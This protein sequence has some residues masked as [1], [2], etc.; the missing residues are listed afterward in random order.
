MRGDEEAVADVVPV[1]LL[2]NAVIAVTWSA[3]QTKPEEIPI[4]HVTTGGLNPIKWGIMGKALA[5]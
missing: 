3:A 4:Y 1:D 2:V 5:T